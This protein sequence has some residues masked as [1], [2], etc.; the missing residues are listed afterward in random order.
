M[1]RRRLPKL[2]RRQRRRCFHVTLT[3]S[4]E[5]KGRHLKM[6]PQRYERPVN[7][8]QIVS[9]RSKTILRR[10]K[11]PGRWVQVG[12]L[13]HGREL[14]SNHSRSRVHEVTGGM[15]VGRRAGE[16]MRERTYAQ[17]RQG[18]ARNKWREGKEEILCKIIMA[19]REE[20]R[21]GKGPGVRDQFTHIVR[22]SFVCC[23]VDTLFVGGFFF[24]CFYLSLFFSVTVLLFSA[25][26]F[27]LHGLCLCLSLSLSLCLSVLISD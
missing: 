4:R 17:E 13:S 27:F 21:E 23:F 3:C 15:A 25:Y 8:K 5:N 6:T 18:R 20:G 14:N 1:Q 10:Q 7:T 16:E 11:S 9:I 2:S 19:L 12:S 26:S 24:F 22:N